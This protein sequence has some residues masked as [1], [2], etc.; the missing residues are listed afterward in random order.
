MTTQTETRASHKN[1]AS[2]LS[3]LDQAAVLLMSLGENDA[4]AVLKHLDPK[5]VQKVGTAMT[6]LKNIQ[7]RDVEEVFNNFVEQVGRM[8]GLGVGNDNYIRRM[9]VAALGE[10]KA[11]GLVDRIL[12]GGNTSGLDTL[13]WMDARSVA[14][15][16]KNEHPQIQAIVVSY[17]DPEQAAG[18]LF[19]FSESVRLEVMMRVASLGNI[20]PGALQELSDV[21]E[22]QFSGSAAA[23]Q[24]TVGGFKVAAEIMNQLESSVSDKLMTAI[25]EQDEEVATK[26]TDLMFVFENLKDLDDRGIQVLLR[27]IS[28]D[29]LILALKGSDDAFKEKIFKN[30]SKRAGEL[31]RDDLASKG[32][33]K[34]SDVEVAQK[35]ILVIARRLSDSGELVL[36]GAGAEAMI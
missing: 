1:K 25:G 11:S 21:I 7:T 32:P 15:M 36:G 8:A 10:E 22:R 26:I 33:V 6:S 17:L 34:V 23:Q 35:E 24:K 12:L 29:Q 18:V 19:H 31:L 28:S 14:D 20:Q 4:A 13:K 27:E 9:L 2:K 5:E 16:I 3:K 30:M